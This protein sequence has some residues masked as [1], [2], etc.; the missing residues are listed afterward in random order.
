MKISRAHIEI[1]GDCNLQCSYCYNSSFNNKSNNLPKKLLIDFI[2]QVNVCDPEVFTISGGEPLM[3]KDLEEILFHCK[4]DII[5]FTNTSLLTKER[6]DSLIKIPN[7]KGFRISLDGFSSHNKYRSPSN[8][9]DVL[10][11]IDYISKNTDK[12][13]GIATMLSKD[14]LNDL[15]LIY[16]FLKERRIKHWRIDIPFFS[17]RYKDEK[18]FF[19]Q[20]DYLDIVLAIK[21]II[22]KF[23]KDNPT[24]ELGVASIYKSDMD[25]SSIF[26]FDLSSH[27]CEYNLEAI[28]LRPNGDLSFCPS[29]NFAF[30]NIKNADNYIELIEKIRKEN[31]FFKIKIKEIKDCLD[32]RYLK[33]CGSGCRSDAIYLKGDLMKRDVVNCSLLPLIEKHILPILDE[34]ERVGFNSLLNKEGFLPKGEKNIDR[35]IE[36]KNV[37]KN[38]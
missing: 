32:C 13:V 6:I 17:G 36:K 38:K 16:N 37:E 3:R 27:P 29:L 10:T 33:I 1:T 24:F 15:E 2:E 30:G 22:I 9:E 35:Y 8:Y 7:L 18:V 4:S 25:Y 21:D 5:L 26:K 14:G 34:R 31:N 19:K 20:A 12:D 28:G 23:K 11:W